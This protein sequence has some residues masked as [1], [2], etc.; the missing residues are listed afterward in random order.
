MR[1]AEEVKRRSQ[2]ILSDFAIVSLVHQSNS[3]SAAFDLIL[4]ETKSQE[5]AKAA[6]WLAV[7]RRDHPEEYSKLHIHSSQVTYDTASSDKERNER[8]IRE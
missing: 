7:L 4:A 6:R 1:S 5:K 8:N 3:P 2:I